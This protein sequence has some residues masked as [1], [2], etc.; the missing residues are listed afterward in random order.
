MPGSTIIESIN[1]MS[2]YKEVC[3]V[4][5][6]Q[7]EPLPLMFSHYSV[8]LEVRMCLVFVVFM[9]S[10]KPWDMSMPKQHVCL[11]CCSDGWAG[12]SHGSMPVMVELLFVVFMASMKPWDTFMPKQQILF[13]VML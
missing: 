2:S 1:A 11:Y 5:G 10:I 8:L 13:V 12:L 4:I 7:P 6:E 3:G 9:A